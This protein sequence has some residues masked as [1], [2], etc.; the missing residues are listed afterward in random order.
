MRLLRWGLPALAL[1]AM[2]AAGAHA[3]G[4]VVQ[5]SSWAQYLDMR[6][7]L[8]DS[9]PFASTDSVTSIT[10]KTPTGVFTTCVTGDAYC[11][12]YGSAPR[13]SLMAM[14]QDLDVTAW[15]IGQGLS[16]HA[17]LRGRDAAGDGR[18]LWPQATQTFS[19]LAAYVELDRPTVSAK[20]GR[21]WEQSGLGM[22]NYDGLS[23]SVS[24]LAEIRVNAYAGQTLVQGLD[25]PLDAAALAP[26]EDL[27]PIDKTYLFGGTVQIRP[28]PYASMQVQY[29]REV[30]SDFG[31][32]NSERMAANAEFRAPFG[33]FGFD[34][35]RDLATETFNDL[36]AHVTFLPVDGITPEV[37]FHHYVPYFDLWTIW[38]AFSPVGYDEGTTTL[39]WSAPEQRLAFGLTGG[40]RQYENTYTG[41]VSLPL[42]SS[43]WRVGATGSIRPFDHWTVQ[44][45]Y[46]M[47][48]NFGASSSDGDVGL[49]WAPSDR[50]SLAVHGTAFQ[51]IYEFT[52][53]QGRVLG[54]GLQGTMR[55]TPDVDL[56]ADAALYHHTGQDD[57]QEANW[58]QRRVSVRLE[59]R[60][61]AN[62]GGWTVGPVRN[63]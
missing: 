45:S 46:N 28:S 57:P 33:S 15:G 50:G 41:V 14:M 53:G 3:Q 30:R 8:T 47:N 39:N 52:V 38:G 23:A 36:A 10:R 4:V 24:P 54:A 9:V 58:D 20:L 40:Y 55:V 29:Q 22:F 62:P 21:Q 63:P 2:T 19:V 11:Y 18:G 44:G 48:I 31:A 35:T 37:A 49:R 17:Q 16:V 43:G 42:S 60:V 56:I 26:V 7:L 12:F 34:A 61:G 6:P 59:W 1:M 25:E 13:A 5:G 27:P 51:N 32:V